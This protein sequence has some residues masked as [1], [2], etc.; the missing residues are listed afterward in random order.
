V[1]SRSPSWGMPESVDMG[2]L[3]IASAFALVF[4]CAPLLLLVANRSGRLARW[5]EQER[6]RLAR[7]YLE[8]P[9]PRWLQWVVL[10]LLVSYLPVE[11]FIWQRSHDVGLVLLQLPSILWLAGWTVGWRWRVKLI[12]RWTRHRDGGIGKE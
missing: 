10:I 5:D 6:R 11:A 3:V 1:D 8:T 12:Q 4:L 7:P 2:P 9:P